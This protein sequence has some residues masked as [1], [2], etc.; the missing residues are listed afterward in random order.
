MRDASRSV[1]SRYCVVSRIVTAR[2]EVA[3]DLPHHQ[4]VARSRPVVACQEDD[5]GSPINVTLGRP[6]AHA[7]WSG[8]RPVG[9]VAE[10][11]LE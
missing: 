10:V 8:R 7:H 2:R 5:R 1:S 9:G 3:H 4:P 11:E 6:A